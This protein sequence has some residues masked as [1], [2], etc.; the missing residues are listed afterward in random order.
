MAQKL[1]LL[2]VLQVRNAPEGRHLDGGLYLAVKA[3]GARSWI[4]RFKLHGRTRETGLGPATGRNA[5]T[6]SEARD[7][8]AEMRLQV[9][10]GI[11]PVEARKAAARQ[12]RLEAIKGKTFRQLALEHIAAHE[13][14]WHNVKHRQQWR[15][16]LKTYAF[17]VIGDMATAEI[18]TEHVLQVLQPIWQAKPETASRLRGRIETILA[19]ATVL[20][21]RK[22]QNPAA[23]RNHLALILPA[24]A[25][26][27]RGHHKAM[28]YADIP[29]FIERLQ[30]VQA[31]GALALEF[32]IL[33]AA[34]TGETIGATWAEMDM[35][36][37]LWSI[38]S[39][40]M[41]AGR[42]HRVP[43]SSRARDVLALLPKFISNGFVFPGN[44]PGTRISN[45]TMAMLLKRMGES[46]TVHGFRSTFRDWAAEQTNH[47]P[48]VCETALAHSIGNKVEAAYRRGDMLEKRRPLARDWA[49][50]CTSRTGTGATITPIRAAG[51]MSA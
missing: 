22:G 33:T 50:Y 1:N 2:N 24:R 13:S 11:D 32:T 4:Y 18:A 41:K 16:T 40:R 42:E 49:A 7:L 34:R 8:A 44:Q 27:S 35:E 10:A 17:P 14:Q 31:I 20:G 21:L 30:R 5:V 15:N 47:A 43:L 39:S 29:A 36:R 26:L 25:R 28:P 38:P 19:A 45:M 51:A 46:C 48:A 12:R 37:A 6:L 3:S 23:W 9:R